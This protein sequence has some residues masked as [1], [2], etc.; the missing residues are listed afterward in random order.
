[1]EDG[2]PILLNDKS[3]AGHDEIEHDHAKH[4]HAQASH[5]DRQDEENFEITRPRG[6]PRLYGWLLRKK[7]DLG[8][9]GIRPALQGATVLVLCGGSGMD[10]EFLADAGANVITSDIS[11][12]AARRASERARRFSLAVGSIVADV[13]SIPVPNRGV[14]VTYVH[15]GLHHLAEPR[16]GVSEMIR[17]ADK[18]VSITE[19]A[20]ALATKFAVRLKLAT[21]SEEAGNH[22][23]RLRP[24][25]VRAWLET[26][27]FVVTRAGRYGMF[28]RHSPGWAM[29]M[30]STP[31]LAL[32]S[33]A[34]YEPAIALSG[35]FG[36]KLTVQAVRAR[37]P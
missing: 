10:G 19:P 26:G 31:G 20:V 4:K 36:N 17:V 9:A 29:R 34:A 5:F 14:D 8:T 15:D 11:L 28:Y 13:E 32:A 12:G 37:R 27:G 3:G 16:L 2:I 1:V 21:D 23:E 6:T 18:A 22:V 25:E 7:F 35:R 30:F 33:M 24:D